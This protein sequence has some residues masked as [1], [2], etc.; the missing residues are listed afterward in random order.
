MR[1]FDDAE[2]IVKAD[3]QFMKRVMELAEEIYGPTKSTGEDVLILES[4]LAIAAHR[5]AGMMVSIGAKSIEEAYALLGTHG[6]K[7][8]DERVAF[9]NKMLNSA[10]DLL[11][12]RTESQAP[13]LL[14][15]VR[16]QNEKLDLDMQAALAETA[17]KPN[18]AS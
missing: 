1:V 4:L 17:N 11:L 9:Y 16:L 7:A 5:E 14:E 18:F 8:D 2:A 10:F 13:E 3:L 6:K 12:A 15:E